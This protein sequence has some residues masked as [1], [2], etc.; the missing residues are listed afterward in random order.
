MQRIILVFA[1]HA[2]LLPW[3]ATAPLAS[4]GAPWARAGAPGAVRPRRARGRG[5]SG[6]RAAREP[7]GELKV[8]AAPLSTRCGGTGRRWGRFGA[9][10]RNTRAGASGPPARE[11]GVG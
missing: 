2:E 1:K 4:P 3:A 5:P 9:G 11:T 10:A 8:T 7:L 6:G